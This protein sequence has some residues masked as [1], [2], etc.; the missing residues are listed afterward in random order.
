MLTCV[1]CGHRFT[2]LQATLF[3]PLRFAMVPNHQY[4]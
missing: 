2:V 4:T 1:I 3:G